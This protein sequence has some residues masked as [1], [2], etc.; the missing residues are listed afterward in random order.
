[1]PEAT[2]SI[3]NRTARRFLLA[4]QRLWPPRKLRGKEGVLEFI[5]HVGCIQCDPLNVVGRNPDLV[6]NARLSNYQPAMLDEML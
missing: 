6:L 3:S 2:L 5:R 1:L 4:H